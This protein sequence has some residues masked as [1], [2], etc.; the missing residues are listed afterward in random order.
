VAIRIVA[1][2]RPSDET[3]AT[4]GEYADRF[5]RLVRRRSGC[6]LE[7]CSAPADDCLDVVSSAAV[8]RLMTEPGKPVLVD[9]GIPTGGRATYLSEAVG[10]ALGQTLSRIRVTVGENGPGVPEVAHALAPF[11]GDERLRHLV[12]GVDL[13]PAKNYTTVAEGEAPYLAILHDD[14]RWDPQFLERRVAF[15]D[16]HPSCGFVFSRCFLIDGTGSYVEV[17]DDVLPPGVHTPEIFLPAIYEQNIVPVPTVVVRRSAYEAVGGAFHDLLFNDHELWLRLG[18]KFD[19]GY[20]PTIDAAY[21]VHRNQTTYANI[22]RLGENR[23][24]F[25]AAIDETTPVVVDPA[26]RRRAAAAAHLMA[27]ADAFERGER[28]ASLRELL[29]AAI[30]SPGT[31]AQ[32]RQRRRASLLLAASLLGP[33]GRAMWRSRRDFGRRRADAVGARRVGAALR[34]MA[35]P[36]E[37]PLF[38]VV[39]PAH[40]AERTIGDALDSVLI[41]TCQRFEIVVVDDGSTDRTVECA[42]ATGAGRVRIVSQENRGVSAAR[43][44]GIR[45]A[46]APWV[47]FLDADDLWLPTYLAKMREEL[48]HDPQPGL[49]FTDAWVY[50]EVAGRIRRQPM[51]ARRRPAEPLPTQP[52]AF[53]SLLLRGNFVYTSATVP[54]DVLEQVGGYDEELTHAEDYDLWLRIAAAGFRTAYVAGPLAAYRLR[55]GAESLSSD[56]LEMSR[57][58]VEVLRRLLERHVLPEPHV[59]LAETRLAELTAAVARLESGD[60]DRRTFTQRLAQRLGRLRREGTLF[61]PVPPEILGAF[62]ELAAGARAH[63]S[64]ESLRQ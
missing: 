11:A 8:E 15:L 63:R 49:V 14:D 58:E 59:A 26:V 19:V 22:R 36:A 33:P 43:N 56:R 12:H 16:E 34:V 44:A 57:S 46:R 23:V 6:P 37:P 54:K 5:A 13:G 25:Y 32:P 45:A 30:A 48:E 53:F 31:I 10:S 51:M 28:A 38:S 18:D 21:R 52:D 1:D 7:P 60:E 4:G 20:L 62:P 64:R 39:I 35:A 41:Q 17:W 50:D 47:C 29:R 40:N 61:G 42:H 3:R 9:V 24:S 2:E 55:G 27:A